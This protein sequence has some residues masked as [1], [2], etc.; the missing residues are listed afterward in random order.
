MAIAAI[1]LCTIAPAHA[2]TTDI[3]LAFPI[4]S[5]YLHNGL[6]I[7]PAYSGTRGALSTYI[8][9]SNHWNGVTGAPR[10]QTI[11]MHTPLITQRDAIGLIAQLMQYGLTKTTAIY[12]TYAHNIPLARGKLSFG[13][14][15]GL[16][17]A[18]TDYTRVETIHPDPVFT[19]NTKPWTLPNLGAGLY[20]YS[21]RHFAGLAI[22]QFM[23]YR[24]TPSGDTQPYH[25]P[26]NYDIILTGGTLIDI[27]PS[28]KLKP[29]ILLHHSFDKS[30]KTKQFDLSANLIYADRLWLGASYRTNEKALVAI[31]QLQVNQ[32]LMVGLSYDYPTGFMATPRN[33]SAELSIRYEFTTHISAANPRYF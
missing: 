11:S 1:I 12:A 5:Q 2:G 27:T 20:Y 7:N 15:A 16:D 14:K 28:L 31:A 21:N 24:R 30:K 29:T 23:S 17:M 19:T 9:A 4:Y 33:G 13:L 3:S 25:Q 8:S 22:P 32:Q 18:N 26:R 6:T 10:R